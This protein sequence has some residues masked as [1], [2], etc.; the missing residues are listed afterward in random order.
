[1]EATAAPTAPELRRIVGL[2]MARCLAL[3]GMMTTHLLPGFEGLEVP[4]PQ[5]LAGGRSAA[6]F[7]VLAGVSLALMSG[8]Q[9][10]VRGR[11]RLA[12]SSGLAVRALL[13]AALGLLLAELETNVAIILTYYGLLF[14]LGLPFLGLQARSLALVAAGWLVV[15]PVVSHLL[16]PEL[17]ARGLG[18]PTFE[19]LDQPLSLLSELAFTGTYPVVPWLTYLL[20]GMAIGRLDLHD[21]LVGMRLLIGGLAIAALSGGLS[22]LIGSG[23]SARAALRGT[24]NAGAP[25]SEA[26]LDAILTHGLF[27]VTPTESWWWLTV[28]APHSGTSFDFAQTIGSACAVIGACLLVSRLG[29]RVFAIAFGAGAMALTL[30]SLHI[31]MLTPSLLPPGAP[32]SYRTQVVIVVGIGALFA[33]ARLKGPLEY[34]VARAAAWAAGMVGTGSR[35]ART[36]SPS[37][38]RPP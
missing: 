27:G 15:S 13:I 2:D 24:F 31:C 36:R 9:H 28:D 23:D 33:L 18:D 12:V 26:E 14:L 29:S 20:A 32:D 38:P 19:R 30:Y 6:L 22:R 3:L 37:L 10:P 16:R 11:E 4:W 8:R 25:V 21:R 17:P 35:R 7:A 1:M 5:Q 34:V